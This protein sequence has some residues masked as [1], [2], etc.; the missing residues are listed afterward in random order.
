MTNRLLSFLSFCFLLLISSCLKDNSDSSIESAALVSVYALSPDAPNFNFFMNGNNIAADIPFGSYTLYNPVAAGNIAIKLQ[1]TNQNLS[2]D[3]T[4][5]TTAGA[6][7]SVFLID[8]FKAIK[9]VFLK[10]NLKDTTANDTTVYLRFFNF[11]PDAPPVDIYYADSTNY[12][13]IWK[14][15]SIQNEA[16]LDSINTFTAIKTGTYNFLVINSINNKDT[17][18]KFAS[19]DL[20]TPAN[21]TLLLEGKYK[22]DTTI[23]LQLGIRRH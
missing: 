12:K 16:T 18:A 3:T 14:N 1:T 22:T 23:T 13:S 15:R 11:S 21:Y 17:L 9:S 5:S 19:R 2:I 20:T 8:S 4:I 6:Y 7:Y 10:D